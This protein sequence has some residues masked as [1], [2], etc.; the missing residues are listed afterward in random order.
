M[1]HVVEGDFELFSNKVLLDQDK[2]FAHSEFSF[3]LI[4]NRSIYLAVYFCP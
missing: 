2:M 4:S 3:E 1:E